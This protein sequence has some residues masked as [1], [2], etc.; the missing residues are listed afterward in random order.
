MLKKKGTQTLFLIIYFLF[1]ML[2]VTFTERYCGNMLYS[3]ETNEKLIQTDDSVVEITEVLPNGGNSLII[4]TVSGDSITASNV[5]KGC[6]LHKGMN[7]T[8]YSKDSNMLIISLPNMTSLYMIK[9]TG[10][11]YTD[12]IILACIIMLYKVRTKGYTILSKRWLRV[13]VLLYTL[14]VLFLHGMIL[15]RF[16]F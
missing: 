3:C 4:T 1:I 2:S 6:V 9:E 14:R 5:S 16:G 11:L 15:Y 8:Y 7:R 13:V 10:L 12:I